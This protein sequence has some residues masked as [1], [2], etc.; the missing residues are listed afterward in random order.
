[1]EWAEEGEDKGVEADL[2]FS[3]FSSAA[4]ELRPLLHKVDI[5]KDVLQITLLIRYTGH[6]KYQQGPNPH[7]LNRQSPAHLMSL[8]VLFDADWLLLWEEMKSSS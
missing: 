1:M 8:T 7:T 5:N 2:S 6:S 4:V 3:L